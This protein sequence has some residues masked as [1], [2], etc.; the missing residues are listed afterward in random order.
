ME[1]RLPIRK[2]NRLIN[3][4]YSS[5]GAYFITICTKDKKKLFWKSGYDSFVGE[6]IILPQRETYLSELG[7]LVLKAINKISDNYSHIKV[8]RFTIMP[9]HVHLLLLIPFDG[10]RIISSPTPIPTVVGQ[11]KR[12]VSKNI[13]FS[14]WQR[15]FH[16]HIVRNTKEYKE[17]EKYIHENPIRWK[18]DCF[19]T[20]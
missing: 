15:S 20:E 1:K 13:G 16:D 7:L 18:Y 2:R 3:Y 9:N 4:D 6:D 17:I 14:V 11:M 10:G 19:Y 8:R 12:Y 5:Y